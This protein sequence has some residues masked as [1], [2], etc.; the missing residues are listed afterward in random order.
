MRLIH[1]CVLYVCV[2]YTCVRLILVCV[3]YLCASY[4]Y[5][6]L[7]CVSHLRE[8]TVYLPVYYH[9]FAFIIIYMMNFIASIT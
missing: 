1:V 3:L 8:Y 7:I 2:S 5:V 9:F 6:R 4:K